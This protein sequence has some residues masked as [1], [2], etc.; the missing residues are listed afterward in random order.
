MRSG[1]T[2]IALTYTVNT[3]WRVRGEL[4]GRQSRSL[5]KGE[6]ARLNK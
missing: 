3:I 2:R 5:G 6:E 1:E 4:R